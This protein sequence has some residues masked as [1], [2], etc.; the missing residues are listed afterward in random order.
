MKAYKDIFKNKKIIVTGHT[1]F[2]GSWLCYWL[3]KLKSKP[4]KL[5][6]VHFSEIIVMKFNG[7][8]QVFHCSW[9][10]NLKLNKINEN[11]YECIEQKNKK[12]LFSLDYLGN[13][14]ISKFHL[15]GLED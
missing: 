13:F 4:S 15:I 9:R 14:S 2:K 8:P 11:S 12:D 10:F 1:G 7:Y 5:K 6:N 3:N